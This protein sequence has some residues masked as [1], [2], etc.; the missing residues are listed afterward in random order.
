MTSQHLQCRMNVY[1]KWIHQVFI[2]VLLF[3]VRIDA[4]SCDEVTY[5]PTC[6]CQ[7]ENVMT[8]CITAV[9]FGSSVELYC[10]INTTQSIY[11]YKEIISSESLIGYNGSA[12][13][14][15]TSD[16][17]RVYKNYIYDRYFSFTDDGK[18]LKISE[19]KT[20]LNGS[21]ICRANG[22]V[23]FQQKFEIRAASSYDPE[24]NLIQEDCQ[25]EVRG[26]RSEEAT[27]CCNFTISSH[28]ESIT[29]EWFVKNDTTKPIETDNNFIVKSHCSQSKEIN[30]EVLTT[31]NTVLKL[32]ITQSQNYTARVRVVTL[33]KKENKTNECNVLVIE[34]KKSEPC[35]EYIYLIVILSIIVSCALITLIILLWIYKRY[36]ITI[37]LLYSNS[38]PLKDD[39]ECKQYDA[40]IAYSEADDDVN[41]V[42]NTL[43]PFFNKHNFSVCIRDINFLP[44]G[45]RFHDSTAAVQASHR[46]ILIL[47]PE[48]INSS[49]CN[50]E[51]EVAFQN[52]I[53]LGK[54]HKIV[55]ICFQNLSKNRVKEFKQLERLLLIVNKLC[56]VEDKSDIFF[57]MLL[58]CMPR[59]T[60]EFVNDPCV[61]RFYSPA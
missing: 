12:I 43:L 16:A 33:N 14:N 27:L 28:L 2:V 10:C 24:L 38:R 20:S 52:M 18:I 1:G 4:Y 55:P 21:Y 32:N 13:H 35:C 56:W 48:F 42:I 22:E 31:V 40:F 46:T 61:A 9:E 30:Q 47:S 34:E 45:E 49:Y 54:G 51:F 17:T 41:F 8:N 6:T 59:K 50:Y 3:Q 39:A 60:T 23:P 53:D 11:W 57:Q 44:G 25:K 58:K 7:D 26:Q 19:S 29:T 5:F 15:Y 37:T 36:N